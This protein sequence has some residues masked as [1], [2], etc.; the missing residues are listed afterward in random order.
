[1]FVIFYFVTIN[2]EFYQ[3]QFFFY[4]VTI[5]SEFD[6]PHISIVYENFNYVNVNQKR[7]KKRKRG[8]ILRIFCFILFLYS[9]NS[10]DLYYRETSIN[11]W[12]SERPV[13]EYL[14]RK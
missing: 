2:S 8:E 5:N 6:Q 9:I 4:C 1:M 14:R 13:R 3:L 7:E 10:F 11:M 12:K